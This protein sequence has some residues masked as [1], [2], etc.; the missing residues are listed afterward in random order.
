MAP[1]LRAP[2]SVGGTV[3]HESQTVRRC[4]CCRLARCCR[5]VHNESTGTSHTPVL[6]VAGETVLDAVG[7]GVAR[8]PAL[9]VA[10][11]HS[12]TA[13]GASAAVR[14]FYLQASADADRLAR[15]FV[16]IGSV[17]TVASFAGVGV[18][19]LDAILDSG[20][21]RGAGAGAGEE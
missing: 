21:R 13:N 12:A 8:V 15:V 11:S 20:R 1:A 19:I 6:A 9:V 10:D 3:G 7:I 16:G 4:R 17:A 18:L 2:N 5:H 14:V